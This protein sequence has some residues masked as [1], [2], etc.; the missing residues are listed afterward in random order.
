MAFSVQQMA[1]LTAPAIVIRD[2]KQFDC[3][4][5][6][7]ELDE[8][9]SYPHEK[10]PHDHACDVYNDKFD[11]ESTIIRHKKIRHQFP[12][13]KCRSKFVF[14]VR[15]ENHERMKHKIP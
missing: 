14:K 2:E 4:G 3:Y 6:A 9:E 12:C 13:R 1:E 11:R 5:C 8:I 10:V 7:S 15:L